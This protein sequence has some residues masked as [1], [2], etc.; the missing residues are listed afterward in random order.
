MMIP[1]RCIL[2]YALIDAF[3]H[4]MTMTGLHDGLCDPK[5]SQPSLPLSNPNQQYKVNLVFHSSC[6]SVPIMRVYMGNPYEPEDRT[7][8]HA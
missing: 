2:L 3:L 5:A 7:E 8:A 6:V 1:R 4:T